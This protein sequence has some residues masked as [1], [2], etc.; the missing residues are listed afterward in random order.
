MTSYDLVVTSGGWGG[1][2]VGRNQGEGRIQSLGLYSH[3]GSMHKMIPK[4]L[5]LQK[6]EMRTKIDQKLALRT[7]PENLRKTLNFKQIAEWV[8]LT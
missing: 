7:F 3:K 2:G 6:W 8:N 1:G 4:Q 5:I